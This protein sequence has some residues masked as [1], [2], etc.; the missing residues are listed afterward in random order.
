M[1]SVLGMALNCTK[2]NVSKLRLL[3]FLVTWLTVD[4]GS[5]YLISLLFGLADDP[6]LIDNGKANCPNVETADLEID[7]FKSY[8]NLD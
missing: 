5:K 1:K 8:V 3:F 7:N 2:L 4:F 6:F